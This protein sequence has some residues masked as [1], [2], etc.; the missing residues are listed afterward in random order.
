MRSEGL[1]QFNDYISNRTC[2]IPACS[3]VP[4]PIRHRLS[5]YLTKL[6]EMS[7][8]CWEHTRGSTFVYGNPLPISQL[9]N[10]ES[11]CGNSLYK[12]DNHTEPRFIYLPGPN[13]SQ[14]YF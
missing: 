6:Y 4:Q 1:G 11:E 2:D 8:A 9:Y 10:G 14:L 3:A 13:I 5:T 12:S 7:I